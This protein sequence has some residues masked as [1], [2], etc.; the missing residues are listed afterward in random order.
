MERERDTYVLVPNAARSAVLVHE[1]KLPCVSSRP[2]VAG[3]IEALRSTHAFA[4]PYL[5][6]ARILQ[7]EDGKAGSALYEFD[8]PDAEWELPA[9][10]GWLALPDADSA[11]ISPPG[12]VPM[13]GSGSRSRVAHRCPRSDLLGHDRDGWRWR[14]AGWRR[15][16]P[17]PVCS[18]RQRSRS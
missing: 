16:S 5:R 10:L 4:A 3:V 9:A 2:G 14:R 8:A 1:G 15:A 12:L 13:S 6:P 18:R 17:R 11:L 7:G